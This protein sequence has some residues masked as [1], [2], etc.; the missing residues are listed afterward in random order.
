MT[1]YFLLW[2]HWTTEHHTT[3]VRVEGRLPPLEQTATSLADLVSRQLSYETI[4]YR[5]VNSW[6]GGKSSND[7]GNSR[8]DQHEEEKAVY[9]LTFKNPPRSSTRRRDAQ[10]L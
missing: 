9:K 5:A 3:A 7:M 2:M 6:S 10:H 4:T 8:A 1:D